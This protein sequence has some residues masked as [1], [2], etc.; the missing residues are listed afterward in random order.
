MDP[1]ILEVK[2][3][4]SSQLEDI[5]RLRDNLSTQ[6]VGLETE[7]LVLEMGQEQ[8]QEELLKFV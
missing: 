3:Q 7:K 6:K 8:M 1:P 2:D 5:K 4:I